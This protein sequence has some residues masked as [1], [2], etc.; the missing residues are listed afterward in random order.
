[1]ERASKFSTQLSNAETALTVS[2][3]EMYAEA[4]RT[5]DERLV[6]LDDLTGRARR[7]LGTAAAS[8]VYGAFDEEAKQQ[9]QE[10][11]SFRDSAVTI[12]KWT[13]VFLVGL[14]AIDLFREHPVYQSAWDVLGRNSSRTVLLGV[15][16]G[17]AT[18]A[19]RQSGHH[20]KREQEARQ[21]ANELAA[22]FPFLSDLPKDKQEDLLARLAFRVFRGTAVSTESKGVHE[23][24]LAAPIL[25]AVDRVLPRRRDT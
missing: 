23:V 6:I 15:L 2:L 24:S 11:N 4:Q 25:D 3:E 19:A 10:A 1:M 5:K 16:I 8:S 21:L 12:I 18:Y 14:F 13:A 20:R 7:V 22:M 9:R 17:A